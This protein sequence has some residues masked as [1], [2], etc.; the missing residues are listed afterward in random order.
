MALT[1]K[2]MLELINAGA[3]DAEILALERGEDKAPAGPAPK[4]Y[5]TETMRTMAER[6]PEN[7]AKWGEIGKTALR[8]FPGVQ[9]AKTL[10]HGAVGGPEGYPSAPEIGLAAAELAS[11]PAAGLLRTGVTGAGTLARAGW[12]GVAQAA[13]QGAGA[14]LASLAAEKAGAGPLVQLGA[15]L[16]GGGVAG[17]YTMPKEGV[18]GLVPKGKE[19]EALYRA[20]KRL[21]IGGKE[22]PPMPT[23]STEEVLS[24]MQAGKGA[25]G[26]AVG[27]AKKALYEGVQASP[28][29]IR[30]AA[31]QAGVE[32]LGKSMPTVQGV[33]QPRLTRD[34]PS[35]TAARNLLQ[36]IA[37]VPDEMTSAEAFKAINDIVEGAQGRASRLQEAGT[38]PAATKLFLSDP[39]KAMQSALDKLSPADELAAMKTADV[40]HSKMAPLAEMASKASETMAGE[41]P[42]FRPKNFVWDWA[43]MDPREK[44]AR[45]S[46]EEKAALDFLTS[47]EGGPLWR[48][49]SRALRQKKIE[50]E[51]AI[52][53]DRNLSFHPSARFQEAQPTGI[54][55]RGARS[56]PYMGREM[57]INEEEARKE[58][59]ARMAEALQNQMR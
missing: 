5:P 28:A 59:A 50:L 3:T 56:L 2:E 51:E 16:A 39:A 38:N 34:R 32:S 6:G 37:D 27:A 11:Y 8:V 31:Y 55:R 9:A 44:A 48:Q 18:A 15:G 45:F 40:A 33:L 24:A 49:A 1:D 41:K 43:R 26:E 47:Q 30:E 19:A 13:A 35:A 42:G 54:I 25:T 29:D 52:G 14:N 4:E 21:G 23:G 20:M 36:D 57:Q 53:L 12:R 7:A 17:H 10:Y 58:R 46:P 22:L